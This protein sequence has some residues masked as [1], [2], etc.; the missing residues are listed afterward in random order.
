M[1]RPAGLGHQPPERRKKLIHRNG[2]NARRLPRRL[3]GFR[4]EPAESLF[5]ES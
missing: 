4:A 3:L 5:A 1:A 2:A